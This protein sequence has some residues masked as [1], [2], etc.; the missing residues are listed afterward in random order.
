MTTRING[1]GGPGKTARQ[2]GRQADA[3]I[4]ADGIETG[5][6]RQIPLWLFGMG[7]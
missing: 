3:Y 2:L 7:Y 4:A 6:A 5:A 1:I